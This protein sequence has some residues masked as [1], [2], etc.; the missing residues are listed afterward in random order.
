M[1]KRVTNQKTRD[2]KTKEYTW[3][4]F[5]IPVDQYEKREGGISDFS[6]IRFMR[7][8]MTGFSKPVVLRFATL[9]LVHGEWRSYEQALYQGKSPE[10]TG[11]LEVSAVNLKRIM[12]RSLSTT[13]CPR[14]QPR[15]RPRTNPNITKQRASPVI[16]SKAIRQW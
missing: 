11:T 15:S 10:A 9:N 4:Q 14:H 16:D 8:F 6:S 12:P 1:D 7:M 2:G 3:Y 13:S 5:R